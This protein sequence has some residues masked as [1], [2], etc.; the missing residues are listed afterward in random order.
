MRNSNLI[1]LIALLVVG[2]C[3]EYKSDCVC[4]SWDGKMVG[5]ASLPSTLSGFQLS[6]DPEVINGVDYGKLIS[7][8]GKIWL[9]QDVTASSTTTLPIRSGCP[10]GYRVPT[11]DELRALLSAA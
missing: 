6:N 11:G 1:L 2:H 5:D 3:Y 4:P 7:Y 8:A 9:S 10:A